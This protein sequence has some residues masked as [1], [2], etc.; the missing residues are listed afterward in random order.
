MHRGLITKPTCR[1]QIEIFLIARATMDHVLP[2][3][4]LVNVLVSGRSS[5]EVLQNVRAMAT[6]PFRVWVGCLH[7]VAKNGVSS[8]ASSNPSPI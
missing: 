7:C 6:M 5:R 2:K 3:L 8:P 4:I 1:P